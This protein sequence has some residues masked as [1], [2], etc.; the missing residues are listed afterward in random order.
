MISSIHTK[1]STDSLKAD[2][3]L[4]AR[5]PYSM[6]KNH[7]YLCIHKFSRGINTNEIIRKLQV[8][9]KRYGLVSKVMDGKRKKKN[10]GY[11]SGGRR[12]DEYIYNIYKNS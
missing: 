8:Y 6:K 1:K 5:F 2:S 3:N 4:F 10:H 12:K 11:R 7:R 9:G